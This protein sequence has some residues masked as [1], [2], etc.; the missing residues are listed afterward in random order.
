MLTI[1]LFTSVEGSFEGA[2]FALMLSLFFFAVF[3][4]PSFSSP[5]LFY[6]ILLFFFFFETFFSFPNW[7]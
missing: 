5:L 3:F 1:G 6:F 2:I 4:F 7:V